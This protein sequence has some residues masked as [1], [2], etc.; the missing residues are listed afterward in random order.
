MTQSVKQILI[1]EPEA[2]Q[3][4]GLA[5]ALSRSDREIFE[6]SNPSEGLDILQKN[7]IDVVFTEIRFSAEDGISAMTRLIK[8]IDPKRIVVISASLDDA[9]CLQIHELGI[10]LIIEKP[11]DEKQIET[12]H[13]IV[14][15]SKEE[16]R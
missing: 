11:V 4:Y 16:R 12:I 14:T 9:L 3:R 13:E 2:I 1:I 10:R 8:L 6:V 5:V 15:L 7:Q